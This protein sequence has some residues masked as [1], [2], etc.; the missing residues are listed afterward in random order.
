MAV[1]RDIERIGNRHQS[2]GRHLDTAIDRG[3]TLRYAPEGQ[4][5]W[6]I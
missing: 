3:T 5:D 1:T 2:L 6:L 4:L